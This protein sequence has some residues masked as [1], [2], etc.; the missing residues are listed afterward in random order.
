ML[1]REA[2][3]KSFSIYH[4]KFLICHLGFK[5]KA[6]TESFCLRPIRG[7]MFIERAIVKRV[8]AP[9]ERKNE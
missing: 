7:E 6:A 3:V 4:L 1:N 5:L 9:A 2:K 8:L